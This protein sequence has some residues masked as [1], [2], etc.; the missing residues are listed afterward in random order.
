MH[1]VG[2]G[3]RL[4]VSLHGLAV[5]V[6]VAAGALLAVRRAREPA[7]VLVAVAAVAVVSLAGAHALYRALHGGPGRF[8]SGGLA[9]TGGIAAGL[10]AAVVVARLLRRPA[11]EVL[12]AVAP[13]GVLALGIGRIGCFLAGCCYGSPTTL[14][15]G[16]ELPAL[17]P[18]ARH[19][20]QLYSAAG[21]LALA[22]LVR[23]RS[24]R[25]GTAFRQTCVGLGLLRAGLE[26]LRDPGATDV[27]PGGILTLSQAAALLLAAATLLAGRLARGRRS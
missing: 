15:W 27:L 12:D 4:V 9:S 21:D 17:G 13:A 6:G 24:D 11:A 25:P 3:I 22:L 2:G 7:P 16:V 23:A 20:L 19:P 5:A 8:W 18:P 14:P 26:T 1:L 10:V